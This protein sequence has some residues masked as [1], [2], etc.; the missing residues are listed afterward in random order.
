MTDSLLS[1]LDS[2]GVAYEIFPCDPD[3]ADTAQFCEAYGFDLSESANTIMVIGKSNPPVFAVC[4][5]LASTRLDVNR[6]VKKKIGVRKT[7]FA[8]AEDTVRL[9]GQTIGGVTPFGLPDDLP[10][11]VDARVMTKDRIVLGGGSRDRKILTSPGILT[12]LGAEIV[13]GL[14]FES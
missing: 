1:T 4:V 12:A 11:W 14:A 7:S 5:V 8:S 3:L 13:E 6:T 10:L 2:L 9:T